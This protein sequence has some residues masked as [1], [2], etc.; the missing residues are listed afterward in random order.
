M[1]VRPANALFVNIQKPDSFLVYNFINKSGCI[2]NTQGLHL[3]SLLDGWQ[4]LD[5]LFESFP[6]Y[7]ADT[8]S[9]TISELLDCK[10]LLIEGTEEE[11]LDA[12][13]YEKWEWGL[14]AGFYHFTIRDCEYLSAQEQIQWLQKRKLKKPSPPLHETNDAFSIT[15]TLP[16][17]GRIN[18]LFSVMRNRRSQRKF[19]DAPLDMETLSELLQYSNGI[20]GWYSSEIFGTLPLKPTPSGGARNPYELY[21]YALNV[22]GLERGI[23]HYSALNHDLGLVRRTQVDPAPLLGDQA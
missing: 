19:R 22:S 12:K 14:A 7:S 15:H 17:P 13:Y 6:D 23:Y 16:S 21:V 4:N 5:E 8:I 2:C 18:D 9:K 20:I 11:V 3:L 10:V 1:R